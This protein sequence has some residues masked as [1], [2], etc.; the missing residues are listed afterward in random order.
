[1]YLFSKSCFLQKIIANQDELTM[2]HVYFGDLKMVRY[3]TDELFSWQD[4]LAA[5]GGF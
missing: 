5:F 2:V 1:M 4:I 3:I